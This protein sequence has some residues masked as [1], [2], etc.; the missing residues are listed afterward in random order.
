MRG[1]YICVDFDGTVVEHAYPA[2]GKEVPGAFDVLQEL[3][4][5]GHKIIIFT[6]RSDER[7][8]EAVSYMAGKGIDLYGIN[9]NP[10]Q[11]S[12][13]NSPKAYGN[14]FIDDAALGCPLINYSE[15]VKKRPYVDW[16]EVRRQLKNRGVL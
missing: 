15:G 6:M 11:D 9:H 4:N 13:T 1:L 2:I 7:L 5:N 10:D 3:I 16:D 14:I 12:W 8:Q